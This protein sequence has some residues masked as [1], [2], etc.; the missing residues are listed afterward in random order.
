MQSILIPTEHGFVQCNVAPM[1]WRTACLVR[2][3]SERESWDIG[4]K[5]SRYV[6]EASLWGWIY[7]WGDDYHWAKGQGEQDQ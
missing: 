7:L 1:W 4:N 5:A 6:C 3:F 2:C